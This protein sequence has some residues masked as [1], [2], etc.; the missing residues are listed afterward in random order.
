M[1]KRH[2]IL[3]NHHPACVELRRRAPAP[4]RVFRSRGAF[5]L[6]ELLVV[7][8][9]VAV[10]IALLLPAL[11]GARGSAQMVKG[12]SN[13]RQLAIANTTY[14]GD[15]DER[16]MPAARDR[17]RNLHRWFGTRDTLG[18]PFDP[19]GGPITPYLD[20][21]APSRAR[22]AAGRSSDA[23]RNARDPLAELERLGVRVCP[24]FEPELRGLREL[25]AGFELGC[26]GYAYNSFFVGADPRKRYVPGLDRPLYRLDADGRSEE[27][28]SRTTRFRDPA[29]TV[30]FADAA[31]AEE[32]L[33]EYS[34]IH[35][36]I[37][38]DFAQ[39][40]RYD[41]SI[42]FRQ[43]GRRANIAWLDGHVSQK[44]WAVSA[45]ATVYPLD[46]AEHDLGWF[47]AEADNRPFDDE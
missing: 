29:G 10:L 45:P 47:H 25:G 16:Y 34:F 9:V 36:A 20:P 28:G 23:G 4:G 33:I 17:R 6:V 42:H 19:A 30:M 1:N 39:P 2:A 26:G 22:D 46:P 12:A 35:P 44:R 21:D 5:T 13:V 32:R 18:Q 11:A 8:A 3:A 31:L 24:R 37:Y 14:A 41:P 43:L 38:P 15:Y 27:T 7:V 40:Y